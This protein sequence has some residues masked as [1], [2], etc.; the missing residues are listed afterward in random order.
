MINNRWRYI[1]IVIRCVASRLHVRSELPIER[2][3]GIRYNGKFVVFA[4]ARTLSRRKVTTKRLSLFIIARFDLFI[5]R[6]GAEN[7]EINHF[8]HDTSA[9]WW[10]W[11][12]E[13]N[14][15]RKDNIA[16]SAA[17]V[18]VFTRVVKTWLMTIWTYA[19]ANN[20]FHALILMGP[21]RHVCRLS[22]WKV[23]L[24]VIFIKRCLHILFCLLKRICIHECSHNVYLRRFADGRQTA[25]VFSKHCPNDKYRFS[26]LVFHLFFTFYF[27]I[28]LIDFRALYIRRASSESTT[29]YSAL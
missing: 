13:S 19:Q 20:H 29:E 3:N 4:P 23:I 1:F 8:W 22:S 10:W 16:A 11:Y 6:N 14:M 15:V 7:D 5:M 24:Y 26:C 2:P 21:P 27:Y 18:V 25:F 12:C 17:I 9:R 28:K